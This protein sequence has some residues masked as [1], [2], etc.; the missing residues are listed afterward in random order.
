MRELP[1]EIWLKLLFLYLKVPDVGPEIIAY[2][3]TS[4]S[5]IY[6]EWNH[7][8]P[9]RNVRGIL[10]G[11]RVAWDEDYFSSGDSRDSQGHADVG[12]DTLNYTVSSLHEYWLYN[13][14]VAGRT[15]IGHGTYSTVTVMTGEDG[16]NCSTFS[17]WIASPVHPFENCRIFLPVFSRTRG[18]LP[19]IRYIGMCRPKGYSF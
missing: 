8:I 9:Q 17:E 4:S 18:L 3:N 6:V 1:K 16:K 11:Y 14:R 15:S 10:V 13:V 12:L 2:Y 5:S 19:Y 7:S